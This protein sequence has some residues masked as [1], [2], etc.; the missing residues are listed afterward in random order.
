MIR[1]GIIVTRDG[2][3][4][5]GGPGSGN[6]GHGGIPGQR[7]GSA[8]GSGGI[9]KNVDGNDFT[10]DQAKNAADKKNGAIVNS[11]ANRD[12]KERA[13]E[14]TRIMEYGQHKYEQHRNMADRD[15][16]WVV[17]G[18]IDDPDGVG[19]IYH[20]AGADHIYIEAAA[21]LD[22]SKPGT[23]VRVI[24]YAKKLAKEK[25]VKKLKLEYT[26]N[27]RPY[28]EKKGWKLNDDEYEA[29]YDL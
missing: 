3:R 16:H 27:S 20:D 5:L 2:M 25:G 14:G 24:N 7:G 9:A 18:D 4:L 8:A 23:G 19:Y 10:F 11:A 15:R 21:S 26:D 17:T 12:L 22:V 13:R 28:Y 29:E 1:K 6:F